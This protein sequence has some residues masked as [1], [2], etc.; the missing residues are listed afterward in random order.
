MKQVTRSSPR[1]LPVL[2]LLTITRP[3]LAGLGA[4]ADPS[5]ILQRL[6]GAPC[7]CRG[8]VL[9]GRPTHFSQSV[10]CG[11]QT[12]Y[13]AIISSARGGNIQSWRCVAKPTFTRKEGACPRDCVFVDQMN[14]QCYSTYSEC[15]QGGKMYF[16][17]KPHMTYSGTF[18][19]DWQT[20]PRVQGNPKY[21]AASCSV[22]VGKDACWPTRA[23]LHVSDGGAY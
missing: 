20:V 13:L 10:D 19:G 18:G 21:A 6:Y 23:P 2:H 7:D 12:A 4:P 8:G 17:A 22:A 16:T 5:R 1:W 15:R 3:A 11:T 14:A 9:R